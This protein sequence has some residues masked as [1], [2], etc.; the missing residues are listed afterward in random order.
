MPLGIFGLVAA[1]DIGLTAPWLIIS[2][3]I[4]AIAMVAGGAVEGPWAGKVANASKASP[5]DA[6][7]S[8]LQ[9]LLDAKRALYASLLIYLSIVAIVY[10]MVVKPFSYGKGFF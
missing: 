8:E 9:R 5:N 1:K 7:S 10:V 6:P 4:F 3:V 2:Y